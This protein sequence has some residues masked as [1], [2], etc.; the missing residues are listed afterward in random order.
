MLDKN[1]KNT[2]NLNNSDN[3]NNFVES[4]DAFNPIL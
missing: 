2:N 1:D 4:N 3:L